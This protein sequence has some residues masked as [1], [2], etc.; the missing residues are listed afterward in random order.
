MAQLLSRLSIASLAASALALVDVPKNHGAAGIDATYDYVIIGGGTSGLT[1]A[2]RLAEDP[3]VSVAVIEA[4]GYYEIEGGPP[5]VIPG[6]AGIANTGTDANDT[7]KIDWN[8][9]AEPLSEGNGRE[10]RYAR[11]RT[12]G[13]SSARHYMVYQRG[14]KGTYEQWAEHTGDDSWTW[15]SILPYFQQSVTVTPANAED[16]FANASVYYDPAGY[17]ASGAPLHVTWPNYASPFSTF[18][19]IGLEAIGVPRDTDFNTGYLD[20]SSW[21]PITIDPKDQTRSSSETS[22]LRYAYANTGLV[23]YPHTMALKIEFDGTTATGVQARSEAGVPFTLTA[24]KEV[25]LS[26]GTF[27][28]PQMLMVSGI[29]PA[30]QLEE[31]GI[32]IIKELPGVGQNLWDHCMFGVV[33]AVNVITSSHLLSDTAFALEAGVTYAANHTG[34]LTAPGFGVIAWEQGPLEG[35]SQE[36]QDALSAQFP[37]DW[38]ILE[39]L[40]LDGI[41]DGWH[42]AQDQFYGKGHEW[43]SLA[44]GLVAPLS[45]GNITLRSASADDAPVIELGY[46]THPGDQEVA[47]AAVKRLRAAFAA[48][49]VVV[50]EE[51]RPGAEVQTDE[52]ILEFVKS[53]VVPVFHAAGTCAMGKESDPLAVVDS[54]G[55]VFGV[56]NLR[57]V[58]ASIFPSLPAGHPQS[59]CYMVAEKIAA[60]IKNGN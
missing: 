44:A 51:H 46:L 14:T 3:E 41:L 20:G 16:R 18:V 36:T 13:G 40:S 8:F 45:R 32:E 21:A 12:L 55:K 30:D 53:T 11:G 25:I 58:D 38:P 4:G 47:V 24:S 10:L 1:I 54:T 2:A 56:N 29:G 39:Y 15:D 59:S 42:S 27:Q 23:V 22:F 26:A 37:D 60:D 28:S 31:Q 57:V 50:G 5:S 9:I 34:P 49:G 43:A 7:S 19:E 17:S 48:T 52:E 35:L 6:L 33:N